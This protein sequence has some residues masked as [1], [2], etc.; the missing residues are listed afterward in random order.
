MQVIEAWRQGSRLGERDSPEEQRRQTLFFGT[1]GR[2][3]SP[4]LRAWASMLE[5]L[6]AAIRLMH[7]ELEI[8]LREMADY[9]SSLVSSDHLLPR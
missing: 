2:Y 1:G 3:T 6:E 7:E 8:F 9:E 4:E 5:T